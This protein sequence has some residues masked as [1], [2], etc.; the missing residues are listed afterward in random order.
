MLCSSP[1]VWGG[2]QDMTSEEAGHDIRAELNYY[3]SMLCSSPFVCWAKSLSIILGCL[4]IDTYSVITV[5][6]TNYTQSRYVNTI[7][8]TMAAKH[9]KYI[10]SLNTYSSIMYTV[11]SKIY[12]WNF[13][14]HHKSANAQLVL[15]SSSISSIIVS[16]D[17][18]CLL[19]SILFTM[20]LQETPPRSSSA[21][22]SRN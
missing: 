21:D 22:R 9:T 20:I 12:I 15:M 2:M 14:G 13:A 10:Q 4:H 5:N 11:T 6:Y 17:L 18:S 16:H 19:Q 7:V 3:H 1:F 8:Y